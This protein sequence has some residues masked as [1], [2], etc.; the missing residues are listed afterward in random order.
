MRL[1][2]KGSK[3]VMTLIDPGREEG[4]VGEEIGRDAEASAALVEIVGQIFMAGLLLPSS[5]PCGV[6]E[7]RVP[8]CGPC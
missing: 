4:E 5:L 8:V 3:D 7:G 1:T 2:V 6:G